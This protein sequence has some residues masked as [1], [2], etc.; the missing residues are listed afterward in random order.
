MSVLDQWLAS[1]SRWF[2]RN[3]FGGKNETVSSRIG[4]L[5]QQDVWWARVSCW[6]ISLILLDRNH[7][8]EA[9]EEPHDG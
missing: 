4:K 2:N 7:C 5:A 8:E 6:V 9:I 3:L 1:V